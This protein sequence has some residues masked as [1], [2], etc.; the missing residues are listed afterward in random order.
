MPTAT[1]DAVAAMLDGGPGL[2]LASGPAQ[3]L[4]P[5]VGAVVES[6]G[7]TGRPQPIELRRDALV[8]AATAS[9]DHFGWDATW[10][11]ALPSHYVA[12]LMVLVR[13]ALGLGVRDCGSDLAG[14]D[15]APGRNCLSIVPTQLRRALDAGLPLGAI[16]AVLVGGA[17]LE[18]ALR[19]RAE[20]AGVRV[21]ETYGMSET[22]GGVVYDGQPLPG[23]DVA[24]EEGRIRLSG[25]MVVGGTLLTNDRGEWRD[26]RLRVLGRIDDLVITGGLKADLAVVRAALQAHAWES[27]ALAVDDEEWGQRIVAF[28]PSGSLAQWRERLAA[29]LPRH[30]LPRQVVVVERLPRT[31]GGKPDRE[32]LLGLLA[33]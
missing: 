29:S 32:K 30:A 2:W 6:S 23:V 26:G 1:P 27:W 9:R 33:T 19:R 14:L 11:L 7:S 24:I 16:D 4:A 10:H 28:V 8:A 13:G 21:V 17:P 3:P 12:G 25:P 5:G 15:P 18:A 20:E 31:P 22:C